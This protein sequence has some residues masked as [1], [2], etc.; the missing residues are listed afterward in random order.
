LIRRI[1][2]IAALAAAEAFAQAKGEIDWN[3]RVLVGH[4]QGAPDLGAPSVAV[5]RL[6]AERAAK[7]DAC[8]NALESLKGMQVQSGGTVGALLQGD[9]AL[10]GRVDGTLKGVKPIKT[11]YFS[12]GGVSLDIEVPLDDLPADLAR[13]IRVPAG[14][15]PLR[16]A[17]AGAGTQPGEIQGDAVVQVARGEAAVLDG[18]KPAARQKAIDDALRRAV[19]MAAGTRVSGV[20]E[21]KDFQVKMDRVLTHAQGFVRRYEIVQEGMD[22]QVVQVSVRAT[23]GTAELD[24]DLEAMGLL[25]A[26]K[27]MPRTMVLIAE[28][29]VGMAAPRAAWM[30]GQPALV[31]ADLRI[32]ENTVLDALKNGGFGQLIDPEIAVEKSVQVGGIASEI[33]AAQARKLG[34]LTGAEV[35]LFGRAIATSRGKVP[36]LGPGWRSCSATISGRAVN[37]DNGDI[38]STAETTQSAAQLDDLSCGKEAIRKASRAFA[39]DMTRKI[40]ARWSKDVSA[41]NDV[42]VRVRNVPSFRTASDFRT[43]LSQRV[44]GVRSVS[45]RS[46]AAGTQELDVVLQGSAEEF[47]QEVEAKKLGR[48]S[49]RVVGVTA[50]TVDLE[51]GQ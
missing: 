45:Q 44:R 50:N 12:D 28:Q 22:G 39:Q 27:G 18:D 19:E 24:R 6:G 31:S 47:A 20:T 16:S 29:N 51:L 37:T 42:H 3:R 32:A 34:S 15:A 30:R 46:F 40:S 2:L 4:G 33:T 48:F 8:R 11:H 41:G 5:A 1:A 13:A 38:L 23:I 35:I 9:A 7:L 49:V 36:D 14:V 26:R 43:A 25:F 17:A 10:S 21:M